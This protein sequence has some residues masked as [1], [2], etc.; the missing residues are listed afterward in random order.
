MEQN[1]RLVDDFD[2]KNCEVNHTEHGEEEMNEPKPEDLIQDNEV[3][4]AKK[5]KKYKNIAIIIINCY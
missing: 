2:D 5:L 3:N 1:N 4:F